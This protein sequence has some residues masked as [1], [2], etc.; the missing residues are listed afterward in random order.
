MNQPAAAIEGKKPDKVPAQMAET[1]Y[2]VM[3]SDD[4]EK[5]AAEAYL[6]TLYPGT[7]ARIVTDLRLDRL[8]DKHT[9]I[10]LYRPDDR[11]NAVQLRIT[12][13]GLREPQATPIG[14]LAKEVRESTPVNCARF[15]Q[16]GSGNEGEVNLAGFLEELGKVCAPAVIKYIPRENILRLGFA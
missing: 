2:F 13:Q 11:T 9:V 16:R 3:V 10:A 8:T 15:W 6:K 12:P 4:Y 1:T 5:K 14:E 7:A